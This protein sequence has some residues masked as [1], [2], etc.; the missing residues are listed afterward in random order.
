MNIF[1]LSPFF[2]VRRSPPLSVIASLSFSSFSSFHRSGACES[3]TFGRIRDSFHFSTVLSCSHSFPSPSIKRSITSFSGLIV[4]VGA[5]VGVTDKAGV[6]DGIG[7]SLGNGVTVGVSSAEGVTVGVT[8]PSDIGDVVSCVP[9]AVPSSVPVTESSSPELKISS[10]FSGA[11]NSAACA[12]IA[13]VIITAARITLARRLPLLCLFLYIITSILQ[14][15][16][17][18]KCAGRSLFI[19]KYR[20]SPKFLQL[21]P[22]HNLK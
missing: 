9:V 14:K 17:A 20:F 2:R 8:V 10:K 18:I 5:G 1:Q 16:P 3:G 6:T 13:V 12:G 19:P 11:P 21:L 15:R 4:G 7:V 22:S